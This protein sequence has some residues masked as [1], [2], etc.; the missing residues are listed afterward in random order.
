[1]YNTNDRLM[2]YS[3]ALIDTEKTDETGHRIVRQAMS[4]QDAVRA[5]MQGLSHAVLTFWP[6]VILYVSGFFIPSQIYEL[7]S[8][9]RMCQVML[10]TESPYQDEEQLERGKFMDLNLLNDPVNIRAY[11]ELGPAIYAPHAYRPTL[12]K[13]RTGPRVPDLQSDFAFI[14]TAFQS[15]I[16]FFGK[17]DFTG[18]DFLLGGANWDEDLPLRSP[19]RNYLGHTTGCVDNEQGVS[20]YQNSKA[21]INIYRREAED[22]HSGEGWAVGPREV[23]MA[24]TGLFYLRDPREEGDGLFPMLPT[25][26]SPQDASEKLRW[27]L[28]HDREREAAAEG[29]RLAV[30]DRTFESNAKML[31]KALEGL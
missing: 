12:H 9:R 20:L 26:D 14:G 2:F 3:K 25:F 31:L 19:L 18:I 10:H 1:M 28:A 6:D 23:E 7:M 24:A 15:R 17:M 27:W 8:A 22:R 11:K 29:A 4:K 30:A 13:P 21:G 5:S 16:N